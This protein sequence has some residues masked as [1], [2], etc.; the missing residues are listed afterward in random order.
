MSG[1]KNCW[2]AWLSLRSGVHSKRVS[3]HKIV[4]KTRLKIYHV[5]LFIVGLMFMFKYQEGQYDVGCQKR[6]DCLV[7]LA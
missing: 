7:K 2:I 5:S 6:L 1:V 4:V 3:G